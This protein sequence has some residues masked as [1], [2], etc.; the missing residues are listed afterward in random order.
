MEWR[1]PTRPR[2]PPIGDLARAAELLSAP[3]LDERSA[4]AV[5]A[6]LGI[7]CV[8]SRVIEDLE[9]LSDL[10]AVDRYPVVAKILSPDIAHKARVGGVIPGLADEAGL[11]RACRQIL[12]AVA[13]AAPGAQRAGI[14]V[15][16]M[17]SGVAELLV[18]Y[19]V[20]AA[21]GPVVTVGQGGA[22]VEAARA[23]AVRRAPVGLSQAE[24]MIGE[25]P[26][27]AAMGGDR[28]ALAN[29]IRALSA[30]ARLPA[31]ALV[32]AEI[33]PLILKCAGAGVVAVDG[34]IVR[35]GERPSKSRRGRN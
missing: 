16:P 19:R 26:G 8:E 29:A 7:P 18:G 27:L 22:L 35:A 5:F 11:R 6:A 21:V 31:G 30:L 34:V 2:R 25:V 14:V 20:D 12:E 15:Q 28:R 9:A 13:A 17:E 24:A 4:L 32:E 1:R 3:A 10:G 33:N 23:F